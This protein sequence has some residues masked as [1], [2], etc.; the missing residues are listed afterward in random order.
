MEKYVERGKTTLNSLEA[1]KPQE[2][3]FV[4]FV[5]FCFKRKEMSGQPYQVLLR[6]ERGF[7]GMVKEEDS[8][9]LRNA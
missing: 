2:E 3:N 6:S 9:R 7:S 4:V 8:G 5:L 1:Q